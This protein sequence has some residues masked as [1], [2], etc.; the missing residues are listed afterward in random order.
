MHPLFNLGGVF[1]IGGGIRLKDFWLSFIAGYRLRVV[2]FC[3]AVR[4]IAVL[5]AAGISNKVFFAVH[6]GQIG[7][8]RKIVI[9][10]DISKAMRVLRTVFRNGCRF[11][12][13]EI[14]SEARSQYM[15]VNSTVISFFIDCMRIWPNGKINRLCTT[16]RVYRVYR[17]WCRDNN[18]DLA[19]TV[20][21]FHEDLEEY[22]RLGD[23]IKE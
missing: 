5:L 20:K 1:C 13:P 22:L 7:T 4:I 17:A 21:E 11:L 16:G 10:I 3:L 23:I 8:L 9:H 14:V 19:K 15:S 6:A 12:E 18:N 2:S